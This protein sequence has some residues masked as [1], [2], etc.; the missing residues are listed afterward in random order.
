MTVATTFDAV[1][2]ALK[3]FLDVWPHG[4][5][6][7]DLP[8][9]KFIVPTDNTVVWARWRMQHVTG[10]QASVGGQKLWNRDGLVMIQLFTPLQADMRDTYGLSDVVVEAYEGKR[11]EDDVWFRN[12]FA[13]EPEGIERDAKANNWYQ[14]NVFA[15]FTYSKL[16]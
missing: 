12:V 14:V 1:N 16:R 3:L 15:D 2:G 11:T 5:D 10:A 6:K 9:R 4:V 7:I 8:N 13:A